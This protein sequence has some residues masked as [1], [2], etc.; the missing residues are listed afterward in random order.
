MTWFGL[1][2]WVAVKPLRAVETRGQVGAGDRG[3]GDAAHGEVGVDGI[4]EA[5]GEHGPVAPVDTHRVLDDLLTDLDT[6]FE[7]ADAGFQI[8]CH[9]G[10]FQKPGH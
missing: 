7:L 4:G 6:I 5:A 1:M 9:G 3:G 2:C 10:S 8:T